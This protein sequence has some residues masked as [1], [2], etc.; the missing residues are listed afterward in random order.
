MPPLPTAQIEA[1][2]ER[3]ESM[4]SLSAILA[5]IEAS[6]EKVLTLETELTAERE[7][8]KTLVDQ[9]RAQSGEALKM[10]GIGEVRK[11]RKPTNNPPRATAD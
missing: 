9:Y 2:I 1:K 4:N 7:H 5:E 11:D 3:K 8:G 6:A 10:L